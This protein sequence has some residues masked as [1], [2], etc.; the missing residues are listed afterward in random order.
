MN[1][2][3]T[4]SEGHAERRLL[5][6]RVG[7]S[8]TFVM[9]LNRIA[10]SISSKQTRVF[11]LYPMLLPRDL[12]TLSKHDVAASVGVNVKTRIS[13]FFTSIPAFSAASTMP[14]R[15]ISSSSSLKDWRACFHHAS[16]PAL[17]ATRIAASGIQHCSH[18]V[19]RADNLITQP[20]PWS[21]ADVLN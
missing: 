20:P 19:S 14:D 6:R 10:T 12:P 7:V 16:R 5:V 15:W 9:Y 2:T 13:P 1:V 8:P 17:R 21:C 4:H 11:A 3:Q 18:A